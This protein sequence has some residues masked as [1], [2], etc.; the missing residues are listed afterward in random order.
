M[1]FVK[2]LLLSAGIGMFVIAAGILAYDYSLFLA[3]R[4]RLVYAEGTT[5]PPEPTVRWRASLAFVMLA[6]APLLISAAI[7]IVPAGMGGVRVS[8]T[9]GALAGTLYPGIH[10]VTS[11]AEKVKLF[12]KRDL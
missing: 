1:L 5:P 10:D 12:N 7:V 3:H 11:L 4:R 8:Q 9:R 6:W 2:Y